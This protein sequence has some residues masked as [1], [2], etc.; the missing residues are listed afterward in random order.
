MAKRETTKKK[1]FRIRQRTGS[2][3]F[4]NLTVWRA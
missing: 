4:L 2:F 1:V 3:F